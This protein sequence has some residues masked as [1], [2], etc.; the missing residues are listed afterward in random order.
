MI[1]KNGQHKQPKKQ[2]KHFPAVSLY[3][4]C[5][6]Y[7]H[8]RTELAS[9]VVLC[10]VDS[11][12]FRDFQFVLKLPKFWYQVLAKVWTKVSPGLHLPKLAI[13]TY[14]SYDGISSLPGALSSTIT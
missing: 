3:Y 5:F 14:R 10:I 2:I 4:W 13:P 7:A 1:T 11:D 12:I 8:V 9:L 6:H